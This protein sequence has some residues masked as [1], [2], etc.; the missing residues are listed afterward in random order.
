MNTLLI[1]TLSVIAVSVIYVTDS[2]SADGELYGQDKSQQ[3]SASKLAY[4][5]E[6]PLPIEAIDTSAYT[7]MRTADL[8]QEVERRSHTD[9]LPF[10]MGIELIKRWSETK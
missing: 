6:T 10:P 5:T 2:E 1:L 9:T 8:Q 7:G 4:M 3:M